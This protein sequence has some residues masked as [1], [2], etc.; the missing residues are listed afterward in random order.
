MAQGGVNSYV[1]EGGF[2]FLEPPHCKYCFEKENKFTIRNTV[3]AQ[4]IP[5]LFASTTSAKM[6][7]IVHKDLQAWLCLCLS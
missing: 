1:P 3:I 5:A 4:K 6:E 2:E 7:I